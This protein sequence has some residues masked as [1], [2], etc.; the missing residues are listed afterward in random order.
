MANFLGLVGPHSLRSDME[1]RLHWIFS[2]DGA[3]SIKSCREARWI[4]EMTDPTWS[5]IWKYRVLAKLLFLCGLL[6]GATFQLLIFL[7]GQ[8]M[9]IPNV[10]PLCLQDAKSINHIFI[11]CSFAFEVWEF[12]LNEVG[13][14][15]VFP[16][17]LIML[18][19]S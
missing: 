8:G 16:K 12:F 4:K 17:E 11:H 1:D 10:C 19:S 3:F 7:Q 6:L 14:D 13:L 15:W 18:I 2:K 5:V 9:I